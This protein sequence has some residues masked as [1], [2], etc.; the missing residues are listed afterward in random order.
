MR[1][2]I[3]YPLGPAKALA[4]GARQLPRLDPA[5]PLEEGPSAY[6]PLEEGIQTGRFVEPLP[7]CLTA[8]AESPIMGRVERLGIYSDAYFIRLME[9]LASDFRTVHGVIGPQLFGRL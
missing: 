1:W 9:S 3:T 5:L 8:V 4:A 6:V 2:A 7:R